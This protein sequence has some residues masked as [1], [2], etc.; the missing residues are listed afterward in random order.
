MLHPRLPLL[1]LPV[2]LALSAGVLLSAGCAPKAVAP[3]HSAAPAPSDEHVL[4]TFSPAVPRA[5]DPVVFTVHVTGKDDRP[6]TKVQVTADLSMPGM[7]MPPN[8]VFLTPSAPGTYTGQS[9]FSMPGQWAVTV[10]ALNKG[11][12]TVTPFPITVR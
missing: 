6:I 7:E 12:R 2:V 4:L 11:S 9:R 5:L 10:T 3:A 1:Y 8:T